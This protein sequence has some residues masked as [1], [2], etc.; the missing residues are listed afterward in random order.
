MQPLKDVKVLVIGGGT[1]QS[2]FLRGLKN[3]SNDIT[4]VVAVTDDGG[5][6]GKLRRDMHMLPP[7]DIRNCII[8]L[9]DIEP[10]ME[11]VMQ[12]RF[13]EGEL[14]GQ[15]FG[16][17]FIAAM[18]D[19]YGSFEKAISQ[20]SQILAVKGR[21]LPVSCS[22]IDI[23]AILQNGDRVC[24]ESAIPVESIK[25]K[26]AVERIVLE[27]PGAA[28]LEEV[29]KAIEKADII[30]IGPG[31]LYTSII[32]NMLIGGVKEAIERSD[33]LKVYVCN[34]MTQPGETDGFDVIDHVEALE[35]H[36]GKIIFDNIIVNDGQIP[37]NILNQYGNDG[38]IQV[39]IDIKQI[40]EL[41]RKGIGVIL[42]D[43]VEIKNGYIRHDACKLARKITGIADYPRKA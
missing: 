13:K 21:V 25:R 3:F 1:G 24:G 41:K 6:S 30:V 2:I 43:F 37:Q 18:N 16:N 34:I 20:I 39:K 15:S 8:A 38:A 11:K 42:D 22:H 27:P 5:G 31:S 32:P 17:L 7:G 23:C 28:P 10:D 4:A 29:L 12:Y 14:K 35:K 33:A 26:S 40:E 19:V 36:S 9:A